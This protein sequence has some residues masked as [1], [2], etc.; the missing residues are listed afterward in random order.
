MRYLFLFLCLLNLSVLAQFE[1]INGTRDSKPKMIAFKNARILV[2]PDKTIEQGTLLIKGDRIMDVGMLVIVPEEAI[3]VDCKGRTIVPAFIET[4]TMIGLTK[5]VSGN[6]SSRPQLESSK[7]G[8]YYWNESIHPEVNSGSMYQSDQKA[9]DELI[10]M[11]F[12]LAVTHVQDGISRGTGALVSLG[13]AE[14]KKHLIK[15][16][17][18][19]F[20]SF[21]KGISKQTYPSS[22][23]GSIALLRQTFYDLKWYIESKPKELNL[24]LES[25]RDD[26]G[27]PFLF[28]TADK[29]EI[30]RASKIAK[31]FNYRFNYIG[32]G[33]EY[34][35]VRQLKYSL[36]QIIIPVN[37]PEAYDVNDPYVSRQIPLSDLKHWEMAPS[38]PF[39]LLQNQVRY[40]KI[41]FAFLPMLLDSINTYPNPSS[42]FK[43]LGN[44]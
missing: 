38:N 41:C 27:L 7:E 13:G 9:S 31:E 21:N 18:A 12:G 40:Q 44:S 28:K 23:M 32:S 22:Q 15:A 37:F 14:E 20:Y 35:A 36:D 5:P 30:L 24:S 6:Q 1:P 2:S 42:G 16:E 43:E 10:K 26:I 33:N 8:A 39:I 4:N 17:A 29:W 11:G 19:Q 25:M 3:V 34:M